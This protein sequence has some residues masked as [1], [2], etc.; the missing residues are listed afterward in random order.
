[1]VAYRVVRRGERGW[2]AVGLNVKNERCFGILR[3]RIRV[4]I[5]R[6]LFGVVG[7]K[8]YLRSDSY[9]SRPITAP[10]QLTLCITA[11]NSRGANIK[12]Y[13]GLLHHT[14]R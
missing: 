1:M 6:K 13:L 14:E 3:V 5:P 10:Q 8:C 9:I 12:L 2:G 11:E 4:F 7:A